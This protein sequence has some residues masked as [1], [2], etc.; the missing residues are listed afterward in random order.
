MN[1]KWSQFGSVNIGYAFKDVILLGYSMQ[2]KGEG[3]SKN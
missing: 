1:K 2:Y 3:I